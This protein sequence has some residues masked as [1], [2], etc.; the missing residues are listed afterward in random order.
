MGHS[1]AEKAKTHERII[2]LAAKRFREKGLAGIG[3]ADLMK[4]AGLT[5]G[6]F[7]KHFAS[8]DELVSEA[9][10]S[11]LGT[12]KRKLQAA[13]SGGP[14]VTYE[15]LVAE[16]LTEAHRDH[17]GS[18]CPVA[19]L[20]PEIARTDKQTRA[21]ITQET[22]D[23]IALL[24]NLIG[25]SRAEDQATARS[26]AILAY[27]A[28]VGAISMSRAVSDDNLSR[29]ILNTVAQILTNSAFKTPK[30]AQ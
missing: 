1:S 11:A 5:V 22:Q 3:I 15:S 8:R 19:A 24:A 20:A 13:A 2:K 14:P 18:G 12:W 21:L 30:R 29:E 16:Y 28:L 6:G 26:Q 27:S 9:V 7:Y 23:G 17:P 10:R 25:A 4:E